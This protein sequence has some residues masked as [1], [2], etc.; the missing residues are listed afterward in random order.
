MRI[1]K[2][3]QDLRLSWRDPASLGAVTTCADSHSDYLYSAVMCFLPVS[4]VHNCMIG[5]H[6]LQ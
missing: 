6:K 3:N 2:T 1:L 4:V 5:N